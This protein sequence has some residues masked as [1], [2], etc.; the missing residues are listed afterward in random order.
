V[1]VR[2]G[3][4][5]GIAHAAARLDHRPRAGAGDDVETV[6]ER[7]ECVGSHHRAAQ[8]EQLLA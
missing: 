7:E 8:R 1:L 3:D 2:G 6:A 4:H 5:F